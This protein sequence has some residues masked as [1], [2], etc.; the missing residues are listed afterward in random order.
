MIAGT[1]NPIARYMF[2][3][4]NLV[5]LLIL[6]LSVSPMALAAD[7]SI[8]PIPRNV[9]DISAEAYVDALELSRQNAPGKLIVSLWTW[10][11]LEPVKGR[12]TMRDEFGGINYASGKYGFVPYIGVTVIDTVD[13]KLPDDLK[14]L[15]WDDP[16]LIGRYARM[17]DNLRNEIKATP[18]YFVI[19]NEIDVHFEKRPDEFPAFLEFAAAARREVL[20][21]FPK[22]IVG[23]TGTYEGYAKGGVRTGLVKDIISISDAAFFTYY[24]VFDLKPAAPD[25]VPGHLDAMVTAAGHKPVVLQEVGFPSSIR[26]STEKM[27]AEFFQVAIPAIA[28]RP[29]I[30]MASIFAMHDFDQKTCSRLVGYYGFGGLSGLTPWVAD[31]KAFICSLGLHNSAGNPKPA[32]DAVHAA[33]SLIQGTA[34]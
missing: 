33:F 4:R 18:A 11:K 29:R 9:S 20:L 19:G 7:F 10:D 16:A 23:V 22:A 17:L 21:R 26:G 14:N 3:I 2:M 25:Q 34:H 28:G 13:R 30:I 24:P 32:W 27:Q 15:K 31:F 6:F 5:L 8:M 1:A 12:N